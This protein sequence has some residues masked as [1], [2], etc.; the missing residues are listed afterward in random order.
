MAKIQPTKNKARKRI[1]MSSELKFFA[2]NN[3][4]NAYKVQNHTHPCFELVYYVHGTGHTKIND[5]SYE[6]SE[7]TF[8]VVPDH[9]L[10]EEYSD[11]KANVM[12]I[13]FTTSHNI[14]S[15]VYSD[16]NGDILK[17]MEEINE[18]M[19]EKAPLYQ[20]ILNVLTEKLILQI[21]RLYTK[22]ESISA[23][24]DY[25]LN[26][27]NSAASRGSSIQQIAY[28]L[29]YNYDYLRQLFIQRTGQ[30]AKSYITALK[31]NS[32]KNYLLSSDYSLPK[33]AEMTGFKTASHLCA[34]F[35]KETGISP[36]EYKAKEGVFDNPPP[37]HTV[38]DEE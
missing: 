5:E 4:S 34:V 14:R 7:R 8:A 19:N 27:V 11:Q 32:I 22:K 26:Y 35:K 28:D 1:R 24:F 15:G 2:R 3:Y 25:I 33:I 6:Y 38:K 18:E 29:G 17:T 16:V 20:S 37:C 9:G 13:G 23:D 21:L 30:T 36:M 10:H 12:F 31:V